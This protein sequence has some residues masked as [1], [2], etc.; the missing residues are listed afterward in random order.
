MKK[1]IYLVFA[2]LAV[3]L[4]A[5]KSEGADVNDPK[6]YCWELNATIKVPGSQLTQTYTT[7][8]WATGSE[9]IDRVELAKK[10][11]E[12]DGIS[13]DVNYKKTTIATEETCDDAADEAEENVGW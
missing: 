7:Y 6:P 13:V 11:L 4:T 1:L 12:G 9:I 8:M 10:D 5:C 2:V 3:S